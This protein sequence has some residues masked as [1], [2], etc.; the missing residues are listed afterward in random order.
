M[1]EKSLEKS[2]GSNLERLTKIK[3]DSLNKYIPIFVR[4]NL[5]KAVLNYHKGKKREC[6]NLLDIANRE[7][8]KVIVDDEKL[9]QVMSMGFSSYETRLALRASLNNVDLAIE[10]IMKV[11]FTTNFCFLVI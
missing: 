7:L 1:C 9:T 5:L 4:L 8:Q 10:Q 6:K 2:Y 3:S 11:N